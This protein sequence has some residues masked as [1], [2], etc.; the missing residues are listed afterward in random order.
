MAIFIAIHLSL[1]GFNAIPLAISFTIFIFFRTYLENNLLYPISI[2]L[3]FDSYFS[4]FNINNLVDSYF[5]S[6]GKFI[7]SQE[8]MAIALIIPITVFYLYTA[9]IPEENLDLAEALDRTVSSL[10]AIIQPFEPDLEKEQETIPADPSV[11]NFTYTL[12]GESL[13]YRHNAI[14]T[15]AEVKGTTL[16]RIKGLDELRKATRNVIDVQMNGCTQEELKPYQKILNTRYDE[17]VSKYGIVSSKQNALAFRDDSDYPLLCPLEDIDEDGSAR[18]ADMFTRQT[19]RPRIEI[20][21]VDTAIE[22][23]A[24]SLNEKGQ[25]DLNYMCF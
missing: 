12:I 25:V 9:L 2:Y 20:T 19:I 16:E 14:M 13:Y 7:F 18:K 22:A 5:K 11:K 24:V 4:Y 15:K 10:N 17:Y 21:E 8:F 3:V 1:Y 23:L 6:I